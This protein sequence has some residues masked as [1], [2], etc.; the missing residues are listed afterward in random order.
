MNRDNTPEVED[1]LSRMMAKVDEQ[2]NEAYGQRADLFISDV[3]ALDSDSCYALINYAQ[4]LPAP[5][6]AAVIEFVG[7]E[8]DGKVRP[9]LETARNFVD[10]NAVLV[11]LAKYRPTRKFDDVAEMHTI[12]AGAR[13]LDVEMKQTWDVA[14]SPEGVKYLRRC[15]DDDVSKMVSERRQRMS[16]TAGVAEL[17]V[18][19][20][21]GSGVST[22]GEGDIVRLYWEGSIYSDCEVKSVQKDNRL[23]VKI[24]KVGSVTVARES[25]VEIQAISKGKAAD[26]KSKLKS[27]WG[28]ALPDAGYAKDLTNELIDEGSD[29]A[30][31][32]HWTMPAAQESPKK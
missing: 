8:F 9:V 24:P 16:A 13:Y 15:N 30:P 10:H 23:S 14:V 29:S 12:V 27:Y 31:E 3:Q 26:M 20:A 17:T 25:I 21:V 22:A 4:G 11:M 5:T 1:R 28:K 19:R 32:S 18:A 6:T 7:R 2:L